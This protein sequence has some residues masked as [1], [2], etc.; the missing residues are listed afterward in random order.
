MVEETIERRIFGLFADLLEYPRAGLRQSVR[1]CE[2]LIAS[3][4][5]K[6][7]ALL[8][9]FRSFVEE[10]SLEQ[11]QEVYTGT[12]DL[13]AI[14]YPYVGYQL[15]GES[16]KRSAFLLGLKE[17]YQA[18]GFAV[19]GKELP[20]HLA[21][22]LRFLAVC[23]DKGITR[24]IACEALLPTLEK[25]LTQQKEADGSGHDGEKIEPNSRQ[26]ENQRARPYM[27][28]LLALRLVLQQHYPM[29]PE[30][31]NHV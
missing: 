20:D 19:E 28:V 3:E 13:D 31:E 8:G 29:D 7:C 5:A 27:D 9:T 1:E 25:M 11:I 14:Y 4:N 15:L 21:V 10:A 12:F 22:M 24:E 6:T 16:Y 2:A 30:A 26:G 17:R 18:N 23:G